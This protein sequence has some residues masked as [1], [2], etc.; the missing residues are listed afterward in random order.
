VASII[1]VPKPMPPNTIRLIVI[2]AFA[3]TF[4]TPAYAEPHTVDARTLDIADVKT[5]MDYEQAV[6]AATAHFKISR[7][8]IKPEQFPSV[9]LVLQTKLPRYFTYEN[10]GVKLSVY[11]EPRIP[12][13]KAHPRAVSMIQY[14]MPWSR[15]NADAMAEAA[16]AKYGQQSNFPNTSLQWCAEPS[17]N[18]GVGCGGKTQA[19][20]E[21][22]QN[23]LKLV[24]P[25]LIEARIKFLQD[26]Q[27]RKPG[28]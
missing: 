27:S 9:D 10:N 3:V 13:D 7:K 28:F 14:E 19:T 23:R 4:A 25:A 2:A 11:F 16:L 24:D 18:A 17:S 26:G 21:L 1:T 6:T 5:G 12:V 20:L 22:A 8:Q 15:Q